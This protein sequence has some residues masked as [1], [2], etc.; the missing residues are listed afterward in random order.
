M[1][2]QDFLT[3]IEAKVQDRVGAFLGLKSRIGRMQSSQSLT[4]RDKATE[5]MKRQVLLEEEL[6]GA[7]AR[8]ENV[9]KG[10]YTISDMTAV[11]AF[12]TAME[13]Q[14]KDVEALEAGSGM[15]RGIPI[16][17]LPLLVLAG[18]GIGAKLMGG[19]R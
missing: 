8:I 11:G 9:K 2:A 3:A 19:R 17:W 7:L 5:L 14:I 15:T 1:L 16:P 12:A 4:L 18:L 6:K 10:A 13:R